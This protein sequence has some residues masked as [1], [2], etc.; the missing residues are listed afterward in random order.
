MLK[1]QEQP[2]IHRVCAG[3]SFIHLKV[4]RWIR[5]RIDSGA[6]ITILS[7]QIYESLK[8]KPAKVE[9][10]TMQMADKEQEL[11]GFIIEPLKLQLGSQTF[12]EKIYVA[13]VCDE[14]LLGHDLL[15]HLGVLLDMHSNTLVL[16]G[17]KI[18]VETIFKDGKP[19][20]ARV[21]LTKRVVVPPNSAVRLPCKMDTTLDDY[22][23]EPGDLVMKKGIL[24]PHIVRSS[25]E[26]Q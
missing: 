22:Y 4:G 25:E 2:S 13:P 20:V 5:A 14:M 21:S 15:H 19:A 24:M 16:N 26:N 8:E 11:K 17:E 3:S 6:D 7:S 9:E 12:K 10:V 18:P 1:Q 23:I